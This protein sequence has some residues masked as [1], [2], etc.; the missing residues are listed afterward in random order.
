[1]STFT[2]P[3]VTVKS[4]VKHP[5]ADALDILSFEECAW[6]CVDKRDLRK[7][8][9]LVV[10]V[11][12]DSVVKISR[13]E[14][15]FLA[16]RAKKNGTCRVRTIRLRGEIS[17]GL[18]LTAPDDIQT[19]VCNKISQGLPNFTGIIYMPEQDV[20]EYFEIVKYEP[21]P[22]TVP[23]LAAG[24][25]PGWCEKSDA[26]RY[27]NFN[28]SIEPYLDEPYYKSLK[29]DGTSTTVFYDAD[30][31]KTFDGYEEH[32]S[33]PM[34]AV[35]ANS[36]GVCSRN[37]EIKEFDEGSNKWTEP[38]E[39]PKGTN[40]YWAAAHRYNLLKLVETIAKYLGKKRFAIQGEICGPGIQGNKMGL[41]EQQFFAFDMYD[42]DISDFLPYG[43]FLKLCS[44][45][46]LQTVPQLGLGPIRNE[47]ESKFI[48]VSMMKYDNG[49]PAEGVVYVAE[50]P[51]RVGT[52]G[53]LKFK[54][55][56]PEFLLKYE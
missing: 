23:P 2:V 42:G 37:W 52:L 47:V 11:P 5:N 4:V 14:F 19:W 18:V 9:E 15:A 1:L 45:Y 17:Q 53:R 32:P 8:G 28:R 13:P 26:E 35:V 46:K 29:M 16:P 20:A 21:P 41:K 3:L 44:D 10:Y 55:I 22:E 56:N 12:I 51:K 36:I 33:V 40:V 6:Q 24:N 30:R 34:I 39:R 49:T 50:T 27:Q 54:F 25:Y 7:P 31:T 38:S 48:A 43:T